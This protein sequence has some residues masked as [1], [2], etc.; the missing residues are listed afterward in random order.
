[1]TEGSFELRTTSTHKGLQGWWVDATNKDDANEGSVRHAWRWIQDVVAALMNVSPQTTTC[2]PDG[3]Q[4]MGWSL[5]VKKTFIE[6]NNLQE[7]WHSDGRRRA[8]SDSNVVPKT[9]DL[10]DA[11]NNKPRVQEAVQSSYAPRCIEHQ[12]RTVQVHQAGWRLKVKKTFIEIIPDAQATIRARSATEIFE[13][14]AAMIEAPA[15]S[16]QIQAARMSNSGS[17]SALNTRKQRRKTKS[18]VTQTPQICD[19]LRTTIMLKNLP[20]G[21]LREEL[22]NLLDMHGFAGEYDFVYTPLDCHSGSGLGYA[23]INMM[24]PDAAER[25]FAELDGFRDWTVQSQKVLSTCWG[26]EQG[27]TLLIERYRNSRMMHE[28]VPEMYKPLLLSGGKPATFP[29]P[30]QRIVKPR[31]MKC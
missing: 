17:R 1:L 15:R 7:S 4:H 28:S 3:F 10:V 21:Y 30:T 22:M 8:L 24:S 11:C 20:N 2:L 31:T 29:P 6:V 25:V 26:T 12:K 14:D 27:L 5:S 9:P 19:S 13:R 16:S 23:F 18:P